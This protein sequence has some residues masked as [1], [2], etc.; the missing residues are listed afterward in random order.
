MWWE[1]TTLLNE[2]SAFLFATVL[3]AKELVFCATHSGCFL[4]FVCVC[5]LLFL[6]VLNLEKNSDTMPL[7]DARWV[8]F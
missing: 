4:F 7:W 8:S 2:L 6:V 1:Q 5:V 3:K